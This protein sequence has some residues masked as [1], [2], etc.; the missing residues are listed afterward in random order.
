MDEWSESCGF[1]GLEI[2]NGAK[3]RLMLLYN[4]NAA[5]RGPCAQFG[6]VTL[7]LPVIY[8]GQGGGVVDMSSA[9]DVAAYELWCN[10]SGTDYRSDGHV[11][12]SRI[13]SDYGV[14]FI[15]EEAYQFLG[16]LPCQDPER[17]ETVGDRVKAYDKV[18]RELIK[19]FIASETSDQEADHTNAYGVWIDLRNNHEE[20]VQ[21]WYDVED[22]LDDEWYNGDA[23]TEAVFQSENDRLA[24]SLALRETRRVLVPSV[25]AGLQ[26]EG[27]KAVSELARFTRRKAIA[28]GFA[29]G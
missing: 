24:V 29:A 14:W 9:A 17:G 11:F 13:D 25:N 26:Y 22:N 5:N 8:D 28:A 20:C 3:A 21:G 18:M 2:K 19:P 16:E 10:Q 27:H 23:R 7:P 6:V 15:C 12:P 4:E 1:T